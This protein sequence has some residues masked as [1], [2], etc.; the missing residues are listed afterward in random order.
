[1]VAFEL[2]AQLGPRLGDPATVQRRLVKAVNGGQV[3]DVAAFLAHYPK[4]L[5]FATRLT[6]SRWIEATAR[7]RVAPVPSPDFL[8]EMPIAPTLGEY[9]LA[10]VTLGPIDTPADSEKEIAE[11]QRLVRITD[12]YVAALGGP[13]ANGFTYSVSGFVAAGRRGKRKPVERSRYTDVRSYDWLIDAFDGAPLEEREVM[14][15]AELHV[16]RR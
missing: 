13:N 15:V 12:K 2:V 11:I 6:G 9:G 4:Q 16:G 14:S 10:Y 7:P 5:A 8:L 1:V 3:E